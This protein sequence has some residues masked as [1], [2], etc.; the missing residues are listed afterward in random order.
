MKRPTSSPPLIEVY[1]SPSVEIAI[2]QIE[3]GFANTGGDGNYGKRGYAGTNIDYGD[4][5]EL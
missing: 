2:I 5:Y 4:N 3:Q 1:E